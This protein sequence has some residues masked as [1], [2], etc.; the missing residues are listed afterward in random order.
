MIFR[1]PFPEIEVPDLA[2]PEF[3]LGGVAGRAYRPALIDGP[4]GRT[5]IYS[6]LQ[7]ATR[8]LAAGLADRGFSPGDTAAIFAPNV[9]EYAVAFHG[10]AAAGGAATTIN[11]LFSEED[12][13]LQ[14]S[15]SGSRFLFTIDAFLQRA[16]PAAKSAGVEEVFVIGPTEEASVTT[17]TD[18][19]AAGAS[20]EPVAQVTD[21]SEHVVALPCSS[22]TTGFAKG[23]RL[24]HRNLAAN[25]LQSQAVINLSERDV[26]IGVLP[27]FHIYGLTVILNL[28]LWSGAT[29]VTMPRFELDLFLELIQEHRVTVAC[30]V[31]PIVL[32]LA[33]HPNVDR[34]DLSSL[35]YVL[36]G[37]APLDASL[38]DAAAQRLNTLVVQGY[39][40]TEASP[41][42]SAPARDPSIARPGSIG[43]ILPSTEIQIVDVGSGEP[44]GAGEDG[45]IWVRGPQVMAGYLNDEEATSRTL[46]ADGWLHTGDIG[47]ADE[48]GYLYC[49]DRLKELIKYRGYQVPPAELEA[50]LLQHPAVADAAVIPSPDEV[51]G[52]V[53]KAFVVKSGEVTEG[54]L[55]SWVSG[56]VPSFKKIRR[57]EFIEEIPK[58]ASGKILRRVLVERERAGK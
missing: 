7:A 31:P 19:L 35:E 41:V 45:E 22:G 21:P 17:F 27:F 2:L 34:F 49:V 11:S 16:I 29:V 48:E 25:V 37:A 46:D 20:A 28:A 44:L 57:V 9:P 1:G 51:A 52:E 5:I 36:S 14:L 26:L 6:E 40:L 3:V 53:P 42:V 39:G 30:I 58:T 4:T 55:M 18:L 54:E 33:K 13:R 8:S 24:T 38:A 43:L 32:A 47:H 56:R 50:V 15:D 10:I 23:V 12:V